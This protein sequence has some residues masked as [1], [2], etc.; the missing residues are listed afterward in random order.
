MLRLLLVLPGTTDLDQQKRI[1]GSLDVPLNRVG[2]RQ[3]EKTAS[4][5]NQE[6]I[7][8]IYAAPCLSAQQTAEQL[9]RRGEVKVKT[10]GTLRN[11]DR[12]LWS[13]K[14]IDEMKT[15]QPKVYR[16]WLENPES[17]CPPDGETVADA[18]KR[19]CRLIKKIHRKHK[20]GIVAV[21]VP[22]PLA[23]IIRIVVKA[24]DSM[25]NL[26]EAECRAGSWE[27]IDVPA[28]LAV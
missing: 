23:S 22:E 25:G 9:S 6:K 4:E 28:E 27:W 10:E 20:N 24:N 12:G 3:V 1:K 7:D 14:S 26:W 15:N 18:R 5:L 11:L 8:L 19:V 16:Q 21:V 2:A 13:G 17:V